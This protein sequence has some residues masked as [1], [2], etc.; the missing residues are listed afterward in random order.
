MMFKVKKGTKMAKIFSAYAQRKGVELANLRFTC[1][2]TRINN[3]D[4]PKMLE[5]EDGDQIDSLIEQVGG[6]ASV[7]L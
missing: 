2:G 7:G 5:L 3:D 1:D 6:R 4:T